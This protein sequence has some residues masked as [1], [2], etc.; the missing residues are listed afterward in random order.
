MPWTAKDAYR[1]TKSASTPQLQNQWA[2]VANSV[3]EKT[4]DEARAIREANATVGKSKKPKTKAKAKTKPPGQS[5]P[6]FGLPPDFAQ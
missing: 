3:L 4:G 6:P 1:H 5:G 2:K